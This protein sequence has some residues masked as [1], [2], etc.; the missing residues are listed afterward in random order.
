MGKLIDGKWVRSDEV[1]RTDTRGAFVRGT[2]KFR[3]SVRADASRFAPEPGRYHL[4]AAY[5][6]PWAHRTMIARRLLGLEDVIGISYANVRRSEEGWWYAE[7][8]D[9]LQPGDDG[10][11]PLHVLYS[12]SASDYT[13]SA[14]VPVLW[15]RAL[16]CIVNNES[17]EIVRMFDQHF[18]ALSTRAISLYPDEL[19]ATIDEINTWVYRDINNG[20]YRCGFARSQQ[21]YDEAFDA[22][23]AALDRAERLLERQRYL[24]GDRLT[25]ADVRLFPTLIRFDCVYHGHFKC[26][27]RR[28]VDY[29]AMWGYLR[30]LYQTSGFA[31]TVRIDLYKQGYYG[32]SPRL[33]PSGIIPK[34]PA[35][36]F[37][38]PHD[39]AS[40]TTP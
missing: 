25:E 12:R 14:T 31:E 13:G 22:L 34:G 1:A 36:D 8:L 40:G 33:N 24:A 29:P 28:I 2:T 9:D 3:H 10:R 30:D 4:F 17:A 35:I 26:N 11:L 23:F 20:V 19:A 16:G 5:N 6:C 39:R 27:L 15:D 18:D 32:R 21:A 37:E 7:G 38:A